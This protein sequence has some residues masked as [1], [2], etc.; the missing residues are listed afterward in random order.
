MGSTNKTK[1]FQFNLWSASDKP[2]REDFNYDNQRL[3]TMLQY[4]CDNKS[5]HCTLDDRDLWTNRCYHG[6]YFG[7][8]T[9]SR[10]IVT[11]CPFEP[12][13]AIVFASA[14]PTSV[15]DFSQQKKYNYSAFATPISRTMGF[16]LV[17]NNRNLSVKQ[18]V[19]ASID[20]EYSFLN[21]VGV[22][23]SYIMIR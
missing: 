15:M 11:D 17:D 20:N 1:N 7:D 16:S 8:G 13:L 21:A 12:K 5:L 18:D 3:D 23:Y 22:A 4:H 14:R 2:K 9:L 19:I 10:T 6:M